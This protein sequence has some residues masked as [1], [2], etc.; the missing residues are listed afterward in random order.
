MKKSL[1][2]IVL[3]CSVLLLFFTGFPSDFDNFFS[4]SKLTANYNSDSFTPPV[5]NVIEVYEPEMVSI[6]ARGRTVVVT[7]YVNNDGTLSP[8][9]SGEQIV[10]GN[11]K[12][13][14]EGS[15]ERSADIFELNSLDL[16]DSASSAAR[17]LIFQAESSNS[18]SL[19]AS[20]E[21]SSSLRE[22]FP[23]STFLC[24][25]NGIWSISLSA[26]QG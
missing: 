8:L 20:S 3:I 10:D 4:S 1:I 6:Q 19:L 22:S 23:S 15:A 9:W 2:Y 18:I 16:P 5:L 26:C 14:I 17:H 12:L 25:D 21:D 11:G 7:G 13:V 24:F